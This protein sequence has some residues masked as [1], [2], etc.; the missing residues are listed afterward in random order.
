VHDIVDLE[1]RGLPSVFAASNE[2]V[3]ASR[4]QATALGFEPAVVYVPHPIQDRTDE[5]IRAIAR[6]AFEDLTAAITA[7]QKA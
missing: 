2:F 3:E 7:L 4:A 1:G 5:E 6:A